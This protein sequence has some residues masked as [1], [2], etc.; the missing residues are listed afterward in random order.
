MSRSDDRW[1]GNNL[2]G[3]GKQSPPIFGPRFS[4]A[5]PEVTPLAFSRTAFCPIVPE[6]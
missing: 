6:K 2:A 5:R 3:I 4:P 1:R